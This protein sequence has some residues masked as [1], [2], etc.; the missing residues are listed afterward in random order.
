[1]E[2][3]M[4]FQSNTRPGWMYHLMENALAYSNKVLIT[5]VESFIAQNPSYFVNFLKK[6]TN[7]VKTLG[8]LPGSWMS[9]TL[10]TSTQTGANV[11]NI[12]RL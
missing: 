9:W 4:T 10:E 1:M 3:I 2:L 11:I 6:A 12:L 7:S 8:L 5:Y